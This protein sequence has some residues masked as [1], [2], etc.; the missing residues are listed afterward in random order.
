MRVDVRHEIR[1]SHHR[2][3]H[4]REP[5]IAKRP[6][7]LLAVAAGPLLSLAIVFPKFRVIDD[8]GRVS[9]GAPKYEPLLDEIAKDCAV[10]VIE[11]QEG[12]RT[13]RDEE[14]ARSRTSVPTRA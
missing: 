3:P 14:G 8:A 4:Q 9:K 2:A 1:P 13:W 7:P 12:G 10:N 5:V 6:W 11:E